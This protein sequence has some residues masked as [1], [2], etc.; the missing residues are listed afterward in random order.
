MSYRILTT[1]WDDF[2][3]VNQMGLVRA[4]PKGG[5]ASVEV[6]AF[7]SFGVNQTTVVHVSVSAHA[8]SV[9]ITSNNQVNMMAKR[10][11]LIQYV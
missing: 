4:G 6:T 11:D 9:S 8:H 5:Q 7:E 3:T 10:V 1:A 2:L